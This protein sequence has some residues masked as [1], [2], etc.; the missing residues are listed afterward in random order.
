MGLKNLY[1]DRGEARNISRH[2]FA[3]NTGSF[4]CPIEGGSVL[5]S[6]LFIELF[7]SA[8]PQMDD[9]DDAPPNASGFA[10][11]AVNAL[12]ATGAALA[13]MGAAAGQYAADFAS[14]QPTSAP[15]AP[16]NAL[17]SAVNKAASSSS[18]SSGYAAASH[19]QPDKFTEWQRSDWRLYYDGTLP[20]GIR[21]HPTPL[22]ESTA[23]GSIQPPT[24][25]RGF[26][27]HLPPSVLGNLSDAQIEAVIGAELRHGRR[28]PDNS[29]A[30]Y[31]IGD[32]T[33][34][35]KGREASAIILNTHI[36]PLP[37]PPLRRPMS[38]RHIWF[39]LNPELAS[40][41]ARDL[42]DIGAWLLIQNTTIRPASGCVVYHGNTMEIGA[43]FRTSRPLCRRPPWATV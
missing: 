14:G 39:S 10:A 13:A 38:R 8:L 28:L 25:P 2:L 19:D 1:V 34:V 40:D 26:K 37:R 41:A 32:G 9:D 12:R 30:G 17:A 31:F 36:R 16:S 5:G 29:R 27:L 20:L 3:P 21:R 15:A 18:S 23:L 6:S 24:P 4:L 11:A 42:F 22:V 33:G 35:G 7:S 43:F